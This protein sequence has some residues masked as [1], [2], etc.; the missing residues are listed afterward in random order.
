MDSIFLKV[1][2]CSF[3]KYG[4]SGT[5]Q[6]RNALCILPL[7][8]VYKW[9]YVFLWAWLVILTYLTAVNIIWNAIL[10]FIPAVTKIRIKVD[11]FKQF[12]KVSSWTEEDWN[13]LS[14]SMQYGDWRLLY[15]LRKHMDALFF[16]EFLCWY[17]L[18]LHLKKTSFK[19]HC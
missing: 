3:W 16:D 19:T 13:V 15:F 7:N 5:I 8:L 17:Q 18:V 6:K 14:M 1:A 10:T 4:P 11:A 12:K 2:G 9:V